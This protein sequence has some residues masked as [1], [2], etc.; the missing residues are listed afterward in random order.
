MR[1]LWQVV[2]MEAFGLPAWLIFHIYELFLG[3]VVPV[4]I[5]LASLHHQKMEPENDLA[6]DW[7]ISIQSCTSK[8]GFK[9][10]KILTLMI[11]NRFHPAERCAH[12]LI[13]F[14][15]RTIWLILNFY[16]GSILLKPKKLIEVILEMK[17]IYFCPDWTASDS[18]L[19]N[20]I[21]TR[22]WVKYLSIRRRLKIFFRRGL[23]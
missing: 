20:H 23:I 8:T 10:S 22:V 5:G 16:S 6:I 4:G 19:R 3:P 15:M 2:G 9:T 12:I 13:V 17:L 7:L 18:K 21:Y 14:L 1:F 11:A